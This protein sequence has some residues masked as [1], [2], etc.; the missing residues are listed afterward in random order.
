MPSTHE[1]CAIGET[2]MRLGSVTPR[3][4]NGVS[5]G[6]TEPARA[7]CARLREPAPRAGAR[8]WLASDAIQSS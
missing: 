1:Y 3:S 7:C 6:G 5:I 2:T 4:V 8:L